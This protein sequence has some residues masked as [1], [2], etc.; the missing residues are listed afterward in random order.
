M[1]ATA[2]AVEVRIYA[3]I[4]CNVERNEVLGSSAKW[5]VEIWQVSLTQDVALIM[6]K[7]RDVIEQ[8]KIT[9]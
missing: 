3:L 8:K 5:K 9:K 7:A 6:Q 2:S 4:I 1:H